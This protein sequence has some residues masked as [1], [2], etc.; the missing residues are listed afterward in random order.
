MSN[1]WK[2]NLCS[3]KNFKDNFFEFFFIES[4]SYIYFEILL[5]K[6]GLPNWWKTFF[7][8][9]IFRGRLFVVLG[10]D[11]N[12]T[13]V[14]LWAI[15]P[16][17][18]GRHYFWLKIPISHEQIV[19]EPVL[20]FDFSWK[21]VKLWSTTNGR[22]HGSIWSQIWNLR[23]EER[24]R[25]S[26][27]WCLCWGQFEFESIFGCLL[28]SDLFSFVLS[29]Q[30]QTVFQTREWAQMATPKNGFKLKLAST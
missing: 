4:Y 3:K 12:V 8:K 16:A 29:H 15:H 20:I 1:M 2:K 19:M 22:Q 5:V 13:Y 23:V 24:W 28:Q 27:L 25:W 7:F 11:L 9:Q 21:S 14:S 30:V 17:D 10:T 26:Q 6:S 18:A